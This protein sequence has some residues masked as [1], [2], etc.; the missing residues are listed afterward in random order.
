MKGALSDADASRQWPLPSRKF[1][2]P[3][4]LAD[5]RLLPPSDRGCRH[6]PRLDEPPALNV[7]AGPGHV[8]RAIRRALPAYQSQRGMTV[9]DLAEHVYGPD[10]TRSQLSSVMRAVRRMIELGAATRV[11]TS[12]GILLFC[13][14]PGEQQSVDE[15]ATVEVT[16]T[17]WDSSDPPP[18]GSVGIPRSGRTRPRR[19]SRPR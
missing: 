5:P 17:R 10:P 15:D 18:R 9:R 4:P 8:M 1:S 2:S 6:D 11:Y 14:P 19:S 7:G 16:A 13:R 12:S 3:R